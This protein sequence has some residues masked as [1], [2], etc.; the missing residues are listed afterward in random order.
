MTYDVFIEQEGS[1]SYQATILGR[2]SWRGAGS[3]R[4][5]ALE[6]LRAEVQ[7]RLKKAEI[8]KLEIDLPDE[9]PWLKLASLEDNPLFDEVQEHIE[10]QRRELDAE[11]GL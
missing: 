10:A 5:Q 1:Q 6:N 3:T 11:E 7:R 8:V 4:E 9:H 2:P